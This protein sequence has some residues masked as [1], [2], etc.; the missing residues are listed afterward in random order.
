[1]K[2]TKKVRLSILATDIY[3]H[4]V[5]AKRNCFSG[6]EKFTMKNI[7]FP[8]NKGFQVPI[9]DFY[10]LFVNSVRIHKPCYV[11]LKKNVPERFIFLA[12]YVNLNYLI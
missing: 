6:Q 2:I 11:P 8:Y 7:I 5:M 4:S 12:I 9:V 10:I 1:M 3:T